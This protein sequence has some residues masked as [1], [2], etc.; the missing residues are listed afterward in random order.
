MSPISMAYAPSIFFECL[1]NRS[2][3]HFRVPSLNFQSPRAR[4][5]GGAH[6]VRAATPPASAMVEVHKVNENKIRA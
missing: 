1:A 6:L 2:D 3:F 5:E 4:W